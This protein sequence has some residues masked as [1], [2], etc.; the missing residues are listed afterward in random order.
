MI[1]AIALST[2]LVSAPFLQ[3]LP[4]SEAKLLEQDDEAKR[5]RLADSIQVAAHLMTAEL[6][7]GQSYEFVVELEMEAGVSL[8][9]AGVP[10]ALLQLDVPPSVELEGKIL[11]THQELASNNFLQAPYERVLK[12]LPSSIRFKLIAAPKDNE[13]IGLNLTGY[14]SGRDGSTGF[15]RRR[16]ELPLQG[17]ASALVT[18]SRKSSWGIDKELLQIGDRAPD[19][20]L[21][22]ADGSKLTLSAKFG[23]QRILITTYRAHW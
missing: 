13:T 3:P 4:A 19:F 22:R 10:A 20:T 17:G 11:T 14:V 2:V 6:E 1:H 15:L 12:E 7:V 18:N 23:E 8:S 21:P 9:Q 16:L 5:P